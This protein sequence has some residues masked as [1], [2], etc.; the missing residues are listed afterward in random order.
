MQT[1]S[2]FQEFFP[3]RAT[4]LGKCIV[5]NREQA[6]KHDAAVT[7]QGLSQATSLPMCLTNSFNCSF[8]WVLTLNSDS[9]YN[10][11]I[12]TAR[13]W[14]SQDYTGRVSLG[15][16]KYLR[17]HTQDI[18]SKRWMGTVLPCCH[19]PFL[20]KGHQL[21]DQSAFFRITKSSE[22]LGNKGMRVCVRLTGE[23]LTNGQDRKCMH[24][25]V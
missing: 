7:P 8:D 19:A 4:A 11:L 9:V 3:L 2:S 6:S 25:F 17:S 5:L 22:C 20:S 10:T 23:F 18:R 14:S 1:T 16:K 21:P 13:I 15:R 12:I 24:V